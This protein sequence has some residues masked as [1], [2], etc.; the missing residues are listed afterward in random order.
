VLNKCKI[1][2]PDEKDEKDLFTTD[3]QPTHE[4][5]HTPEREGGREY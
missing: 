1:E 2:I 3:S 4:R 5:T